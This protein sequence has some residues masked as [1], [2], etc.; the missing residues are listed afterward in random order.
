MSLGSTV[1]DSS[2]TTLVDSA[3]AGSHDEASLFWTSTSLAFRLLIPPAITSAA[4]TTIHFVTRPVSRPAICRCMFRT[5]S[6]SGGSRH[7]GFPRSDPGDPE[8]SSVPG[9]TGP[10]ARPRLPQRSSLNLST[11]SRGPDTITTSPSS[12]TVSAVA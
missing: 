4:T 6:G 3:E 5:L 12:I 7:R 8:N 9:R 10:A 1:P 11:L 2:S